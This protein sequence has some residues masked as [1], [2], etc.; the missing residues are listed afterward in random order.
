MQTLPIE[1]IRLIFSFEYEQRYVLD[2]KN[3]I[4]TRISRYDPRKSVRPGILRWNN[5]RT[6]FPESVSMILPFYPAFTPVSH[7]YMIVQKSILSDIDYV[8]LIYSEELDSY[9][10]RQTEYQLIDRRISNIR[11]R[12]RAI[13][14][15]QDFDDRVVRDEYWIHGNYSS[16]P[17]DEYYGMYYSYSYG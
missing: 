2:D 15:D 10:H 8:V 12:N 9:V 1:I 3:R 5:L 11:I 4:H 7:M 17:I 14:H 16:D 13:T 6:H